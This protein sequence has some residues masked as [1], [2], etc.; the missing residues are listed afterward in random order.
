MGNRC[1]LAFILWHG[2]LY[3]NNSQIRVKI[4]LCD[5]KT[6][7]LFCALCRKFRSS[8]LRTY[9]FALKLAARFCMGIL[10]RLFFCRTSICPKCTCRCPRT[11]TDTLLLW[12]HMGQARSLA[13]L[14][15]RCTG[16]IRLCILQRL[17]ATPRWN[18]LATKL[19]FPA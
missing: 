15:N 7:E 6:E 1:G 8:G 18:S 13:C 5:K 16:F 19:C 11:R 14:P 4:K 3:A 17:A 12:L 2:S 10:N 9:S